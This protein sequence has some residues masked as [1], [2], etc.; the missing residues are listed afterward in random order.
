MH[1]NDTQLLAP[2]K[3][4]FQTLIKA[5]VKKTEHKKHNIVT[6]PVILIAVMAVLNI[7]S[8]LSTD[9]SDWY[10]ENIFPLWNNTVSRL[11]GMFSFSVGE[12]LIAIGIIILLAGPAAFIICI[13]VLKK[14]RKKVCRLT[15][16]FLLLVFTYITVT[17]TLNCFIMYHC[18]PFSEKYMAV[19]D[20]HDYEQLVGLCNIL[21]EKANYYSEKVERDESGNAIVPDNLNELTKQAMIN[22]SNDYPMISGYYPDAKKIMSS[23]FMTQLSL[24]GVYF[25]FTLEA[26]YNKDMY[27]LNFPDTICHEMS[28]LKGFI[29]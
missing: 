28:H 14:Q 8:W 12:I 20:E 18:T 16:I 2:V 25:P 26:N 19:S 7:V 1:S 10:A 17:E 27:S 13:I 3:L 29:Q 21:I 24:K 9:F 11:T 6:I 4:D 15:A 23:K 5:N 22:I